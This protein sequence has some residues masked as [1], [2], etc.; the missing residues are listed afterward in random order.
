MS[1]QENWQSFRDE[2]V[3][4]NISVDILINNAGFMLPFSKFENYSDADINEIVNTNFLSVVNST[5]ILLPLIKKSKTPTIINIASAAGLCA[6][7]GQSMYCATKFAVKGFAAQK[8]LT[9]TAGDIH[10][11]ERRDF[12]A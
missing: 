10:I 11:A 3:D 4:N 8:S 2:L 7:V 6:V 5:K 1:R 12:S 9:R